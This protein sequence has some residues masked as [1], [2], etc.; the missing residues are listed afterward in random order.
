[1]RIRAKLAAAGV[2][3]VGRAH[4]APGESPPPTRR[5]EVGDLEMAVG[6]GDEPDAYA[7]Q[8]NSV[9]LLLFHDGQPVSTWATACR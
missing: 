8:P 5:R 4:P 1:M 2:L 6:F 9:Q 7:G 3:A